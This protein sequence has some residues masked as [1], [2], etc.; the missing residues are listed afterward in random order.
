MKQKDKNNL[1][2]YFKRLKQA[3]E[4]LES[5]VSED[6]LGNY[7]D[8]LKESKNAEEADDRKENKHE[9]FNKWMAYLLIANVDQ[10]KYASFSNG[11]AIQYSIKTNT[12]KTYYQHQR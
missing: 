12:P 6:I 5:H 1:I 4:I 10:S 11:L 7:V 9:E 8:N 2:D 3:K